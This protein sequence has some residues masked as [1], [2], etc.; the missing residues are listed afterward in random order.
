MRRPLRSHR[1]PPS[2]EPPEAALQAGTEHPN[3]N[4][5]RIHSSENLPNEN[6]L[7]PTEPDGIDGSLTPQGGT[8]LQSG[9]GEAQGLGSEAGEARAAGEGAEGIEAAEGI[10]QAETLERLVL[11]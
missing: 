2:T 10:A 7:S 4:S 9:S 3:E 8:G 6:T 11:L 5:L 1:R